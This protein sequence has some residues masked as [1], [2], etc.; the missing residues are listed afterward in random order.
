MPTEPE[1]AA[2]AK[3]LAAAHSIQKGSLAPFQWRKVAARALEAAEAAR[4]T[5]I[6]DEELNRSSIGGF[7]DTMARELLA[8]ADEIERRGELKKAAGK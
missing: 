7:I 2:V 4:S 6:I 5:I 8:A 1:I 3:V